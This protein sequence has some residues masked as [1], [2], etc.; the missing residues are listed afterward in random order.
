M[1]APAAGVS[2]RAAPG[3]R[4]RLGRCADS[5]PGR[6]AAEDPIEQRPRVYADPRPTARSPGSS[7]P[8]SRSA[9]SQHPGV[10]ST[11]CSASMGPSPAAFV[12]A[13]EPGR[14]AGPL[15]AVRPPL[16]ARPGHRRAARHPAA[17]ARHPRARSSSSS[18]RA[19]TRPRPTSGPASSRSA[20][21]RGRWTCGRSTAGRAGRPG[22]HALLPAAVRRQRLQA[23][24]SV[25]ALDG[26]AR[27]RRPRR[28]DARVAG[29]PDHPARRARRSASAGA[30]G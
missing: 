5:T 17:H 13:F 10:H 2:K 26:P 18:S 11:R 9:A 16:D 30:W 8:A 7:P 4:P 24:Q 25:P 20:P 27:R 23:A 19:T 12:R 22:V 21:A 28:L 15:R 3:G 29:A 14:D 1:P 6:R